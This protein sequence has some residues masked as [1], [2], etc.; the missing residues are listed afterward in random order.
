MAW[1][2]LLSGNA[3]D[4]FVELATPPLKPLTESARFRYLARLA[5]RELL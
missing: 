3:T 4:K 1:K 2:A 5:E